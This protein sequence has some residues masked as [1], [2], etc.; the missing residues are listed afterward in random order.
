MCIFFAFLRIQPIFCSHKSFKVH[1]SKACHKYLVA[2]PG[3]VITPSMIASLVAE[4]WPQSVTPL[5]IL[6]GFK[7]CGIYPINPGE[8][9]DRLLAPSKGVRPSTQSSST[10]SFTPEQQVLYQKRYEEGY[11]IADPGYT[12]WL[13]I[14]HPSG[15]QSTTSTTGS[16]V[17]S[18]SPKSS[19]CSIVTHATKS[20]SSSLP[21]ESDTA[22]SV[23]SPS[24]CSSLSD[25]LVLPKPVSRKSSKSK[26]S[27]N[28]KAQIITDDAIV[29][30]LKE[31]EREKVEKEAMKNAR[32]LEMEKKR[33]E[34]EQMKK[35][36]E[37]EKEE[38]RIQKMEKEKEK[39][40][41]K[42]ER[43]QKK[44]EKEQQKKEKEQRKKEKKK[45]AEQKKGQKV[46]DKMP[47]HA[48]EEDTCICPKCGLVY[49]SS[50]D[51]STW[52]GCDNCDNWYNISCTS[53]KS[54]DNIP[55]EYLC[56][57]CA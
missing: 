21:E 50:E 13:K 19:E 32:K 30:E 51:Y 26:P 43:E 6:S 12:E 16:I 44:K 46:K 40:Q 54:C 18:E 24:V 10:E 34:K 35:E 28:S 55:E 22:S 57:E 9:S 1:F 25:I 33:K 11:D 8:I 56:D 47:T 45:E 48:Q 23:T 4:A 31:K 5:N 36:K 39:E 38:R 14:H 37:K 53:I 52:I 17:L 42:K 49:G 29:E 15:S 20:I 3:R 27:I 41:R 2:N 7:K